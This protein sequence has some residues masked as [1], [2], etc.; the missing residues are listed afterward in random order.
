V[1][2]PTK[3]LLCPE[4]GFSVLAEAFADVPIIGESPDDRLRKFM[5]RL[6]QHIQE[7]GGKEARRIEHLQRNNGKVLQITDPAQ[8]AAALMLEHG[9][10]V[11][12]LASVPVFMNMAR[13][14]LVA[15]AFETTDPK[16]NE[17]K[18]AARAHLHGSTRKNYL[19]D[20]TILSHVAQLGLD[21]QDA[22]AVYAL[23]QQMRDILCEEND[24]APG[25]VAM[26][27][28]GPGVMII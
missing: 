19:T 23:M 25:G 27:R 15:S 3:C 12:L 6:E 4:P 24:Y 8:Q 2:H 7:Q 1:K 26:H 22:D 13:A 28:E 9:K 17:M 18:E 16:L 21:Q 11:S 20:A 5:M 10:H 14:H